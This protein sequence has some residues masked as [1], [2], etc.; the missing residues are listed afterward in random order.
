LFSSSKTRVDR[1]VLDGGLYAGL[2]DWQNSLKCTDSTTENG[3][4]HPK[5][6]F[7]NLK[8]TESISAFVILSW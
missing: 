5:N 8:L 6:S 7:P 4:L 3:I 2:N 1:V